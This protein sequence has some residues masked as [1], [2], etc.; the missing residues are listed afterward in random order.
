MELMSK[1]TG[2]TINTEAIH[3]GDFVRAKYDKWEE[4]RNGLVARVT[5][6]EIRVIWQPGIRNV[7]NYFVMYANEITDG[8]WTI[9]WSPDM[10]TINTHKP[11]GGPE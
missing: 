1:A 10:E 9:T 7:V 5:E 3:V 8:L 4:E 6:G 2:E 11:S